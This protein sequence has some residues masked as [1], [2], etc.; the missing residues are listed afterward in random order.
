MNRPA[1][2]VLALLLAGCGGDSPGSPSAGTTP[3]SAVTTAPSPTGTS[4]SPSTI[5]TAVLPTGLVA[6]PPRPTAATAAGTGAPVPVRAVAAPGRY[7]ATQSGSE[8]FSTAGSSPMERPFPPSTDLVVSGSGDTRVFAIEYSP[9]RSDRLTLRFSNGRIDLVRAEA[10][11]RVGDYTRT[12]VI[13]PSPPIPVFP[14]NARVGQRYSGT[15]T[16]DRASG[17]Y[18]GAVLRRE[19]GALVVDLTIRITSGDVT[20]TLRSTTNWDTARA[21][22]VKQVTDARLGDALNTYRQQSTITL[23]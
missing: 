2:L 18:E 8:S 7:P 15:F 6:S 19:G 21:L 23:R 17:N 12:Q 13:V 20:G 22:P 4:A 11:I 3:P 10:T 16:G 9:D 1:L 5:P 14:A